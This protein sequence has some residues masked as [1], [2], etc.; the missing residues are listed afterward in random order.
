MTAKKKRLTIISIIFVALLIMTGVV[1]FCI[2]KY[3]AGQRYLQYEELEPTQI[4]LVY[5]KIWEYKDE[6]SKELI[7]SIIAVDAEGDR[8]YTEL[9]YE[10]WNGIETFFDE[11]LNG[12]KTVNYIYNEDMAE[13]YGYLLQ[14]D[15]SVGYYDYTKEEVPCVTPLPYSKGNFYCIRYKVNGS[16]EYIKYWEQLSYCDFCILNDPITEKINRIIGRPL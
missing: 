11:I 2:S 10:G 13:I 1:F 5:E 8:Y 7:V 3:K 4:V 6:D 15:V 12:E 16:K 14:T 9:P